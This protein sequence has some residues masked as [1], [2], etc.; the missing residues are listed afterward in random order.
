MDIRLLLFEIS[1][2]D[3]VL[4]TA[5]YVVIVGFFVTTPSLRETSIGSRFCPANHS[6]ADKEGQALAVAGKMS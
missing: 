6:A 4:L 2:A 3:G 1:V 5:L